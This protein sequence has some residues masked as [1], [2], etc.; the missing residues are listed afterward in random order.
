MTAAERQSYRQAMRAAR[1][2]PARKRQLREQWTST[3]NARAA[4]R[5]GVLARPA[6]VRPSQN[7][8]RNNKPSAQ[9]QPNRSANPP[10]RAP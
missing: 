6:F 5:G 9:R 8:A 7:D 2:D 4:Q 3:L 10:P 1:T